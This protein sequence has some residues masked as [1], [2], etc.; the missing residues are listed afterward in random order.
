M[1]AFRAERSD[2]KNCRGG[3]TQAKSPPKIPCPPKPNKKPI[4]FQKGM[5]F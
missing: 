5:D 4:I 1:L 3:I 2:A